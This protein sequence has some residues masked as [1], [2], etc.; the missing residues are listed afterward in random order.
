MDSAA[1]VRRAA[2]RGRPFGEMAIADS[3]GGAMVEALEAREL[4]S[5]TWYVSPSGG[6]SNPGTL[7][8]PFKTIQEAA[9]VAKAGDHVE[10][11][12]GVYHETVTPAHSGTAAAP[13]VY[14]AYKGENVTVSGA[15]AIT[16]WT[17]YKGSIYGAPMSWDLGEGNNEIFVNGVGMNE[18][19]FP[20][21]AIGGESHP[22]TLKMTSVKGN[23]IYNA[24]LNQPANYWKGAIIRMAP[25]QS[26][27]G[28]TGTVTSSAPGSITI[29]YT[30][31]NSAYE[32]VVAGNT[33]SLFGKFAA[34]DTA[35]EWY[36]DPTTGRLYLWAPSGGNP[37]SVDVEAKHRLYAFNLNSASYITIH[38]VN[39]FAATITTSSA[40]RN[41]VIN[42]ITAQYVSQAAEIPHGWSANIEGIMLKGVDDVLE[43]STVAFS[44]G[45]AVEASGAGTI[46]T[47]NVIHDAAYTGENTGAVWLLGSSITVSHNT[48]YNSGRHGVMAEVPKANII[49]NTIHDVG[50]QTTEA[51]GV[52]T[53]NTNGQGGVIA[54]NQIYNIHTGG[55]GGT[56]LFTDNYSSNWVV[57]HNITWNVDYGLKMNY[58]SNNN[59]I[60]DNTLGATILS[61]NSNQIGN[62]NGVQIYGNVFT[63]SIVTTPGAKIYD[64]VEASSSKTLG[65]GDFSSGAS[66]VVSVTPPTSTG[67][68]TPPV[69]TPPVTTTAPASRTATA[70]ISALTYNAKSGVVPDTYGGMG[71]NGGNWA[72]YSQVNFGTGVTSFTANIAALAQYAGTVQIRL[73]SPTGTLVGSLKITGTGAWN[74]YVSQTTAIKGA[75]GVHN[76]YLVFVGGGGTG[77]ISSF[78]FSAAVVK[79]VTTRLATTAIAATSYNADLGI[80]ADGYGGIGTNGGNWVEY[81]DINFGTGVSTFKANIA[82]L[83]KYAGTIQIR[84][85]SPT[86]TLVG[87]LKVAGTG[88][89]NKYAAQSTAVKGATGLHNLYL[90]F[91]GGGGTGNIS[92]FSFA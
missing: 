53:A 75:T 19:E 41:V 22:G 58:T 30:I 44:S 91:V 63:K 54:Y 11:E 21:T 49:Y 2:S 68:T 57:D 61:I 74:K 73:D 64:N 42:G 35:G 36:R 69:T 86:G 24:S 37:S 6:N 47:N 38:G 29:S 78:S 17:D 65:A 15:D 52:Y 77:N 46:I 76:L 27:D 10:I 82:A 66:G 90:V 13:I 45:D 33:F 4:L 25:G 40:S 79:T 71:T 92:S 20:N 81:S 8:A 14:E 87:T 16:G 80:A 34:L 5:S 59:K 43:N 31:N 83:A 89:W 23:T 56:A 88:A 55:Y 84:L 72:E 60:Y 3:C 12:T 85:D 7:A 70:S 18:A 62:W 9:N 51:G 39:V 1:L 26:W 32:K 48:I 67:T 50:L 28:E